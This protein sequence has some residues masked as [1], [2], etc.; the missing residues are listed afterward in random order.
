MNRFLR[1]GVVGAAVYVLDTLS[2][3]ALL[4]IGLPRLPARLGALVLAVFA[5]WLANRGW[6][7]RQQTRA[8]PPTLGEFGRF[9]ATQAAGAGVNAL[10]SLA[11]LQVAAIA[12]IG[13]WGA[14]GLGS[15]A[16]MCVNFAGAR[17]FVY[18][19]PG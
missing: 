19:G 15:M 3:A 10:V 1:F 17:R 18:R 5:S 12:Q 2:F 8:R 11:A 16:G 13:P 14:V 9:A 7:F 4:G 6:T